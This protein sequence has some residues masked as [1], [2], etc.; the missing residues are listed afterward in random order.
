MSRQHAFVS[1]LV[2][3]PL[4]ALYAHTSFLSAPGG[5]A[6]LQTSMSLGLKAPLTSRQRPERAEMTAPGG[7]PAGPV[8]FHWSADMPQA[9]VSQPMGA[10]C[11]LPAAAAGGG[12]HGRRTAAS[13]RRA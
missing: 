2:K 4:V 13:P 10:A 8:R 11:A 3:A 12:V 1:R 6:Q 7:E 9:S 5:L